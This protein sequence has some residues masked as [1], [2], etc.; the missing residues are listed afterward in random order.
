[1]L[2]QANQTSFKKGHVMSEETRRKIGEA[3]K[4]RVWTQEQRDN[5]SRIFKGRTFTKEWKEKISTTL[6]DGRRVGKKAANYK[7]GKYAVIGRV[8][9]EAPP[10]PEF[11]EACGIPGTSHKYGLYVDHCHKTEKFRGWLCQGCNSALGHVKD[12]PEVLRKLAE[13]L[14]KHL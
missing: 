10:E 13:Y 6:K 12:K 4:K 1:M 2:R 5:H 7:H 9:R 3:S 8:K 14:E 11:C